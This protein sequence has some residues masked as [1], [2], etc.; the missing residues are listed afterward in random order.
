MKSIYSFWCLCLILAVLGSRSN[1]QSAYSIPFASQG[2]TIE[3]SVANV[4]SAAAGRV[5]VHVTNVP[6]WIRFAETERQI[7]SVK[8]GEEGTVAFSFSIEKSAPVDREHTLRFVIASST[9]EKWTKE[10]TVAVAVPEQFELLSLIHISE[11][12]RPY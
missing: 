11:P 10:I 3:L 8:A 9:G 2:N 12:T 6:S 4:S 7:P 1:A 5:R